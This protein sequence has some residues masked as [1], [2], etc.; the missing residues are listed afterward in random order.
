MGRA[1]IVV[2]ED[3]AVLSTASS[4]RPIRL[5]AADAFF[6]EFDPDTVEDPEPDEA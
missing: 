2:M 4:W 3:R 1:D 6:Q 5:L